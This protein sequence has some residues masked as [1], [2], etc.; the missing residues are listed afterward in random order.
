MPAHVYS[1]ALTGLDGEI[2]EVE[3]DFADG[4]PGMVIVGL[5]DAAVQES[6]ERVQSAVKNS[7]LFYPRQRFIVNLAPASVRKEGPA[8]DLPIAIGALIMTGQ[9]SQE[10]LDGSL[11]LGEL[12]LN[13]TVRHVRGV[14]SMAAAARQHGYKR[15]FVPES[16]AAEAAIIPD[17]DVIPVSS[18]N[19]LC[20][21]L[22]GRS[23]ITVQQKSEIESEDLTAQTD[24]QDI[25]G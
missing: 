11:V 22:N 3:V 6:R 20:Q 1:C 16:D 9:I 15:V 19:Q 8:F 21:H 7:N 17:L 25:K 4:L 14:I 13:G 12:S 18:L 23:Q 10:A 24:F 5:P 2:I